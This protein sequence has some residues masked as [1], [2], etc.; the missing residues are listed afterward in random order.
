MPIYFRVKSMSIHSNCFSFDKRRTFNQ[1]V[2]L[3]VFESSQWAGRNGLNGSGFGV[4]TF[5]RV[6]I[7][8]VKTNQVLNRCGNLKRIAR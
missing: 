7:T 8:S 6:Q 4:D 1:M 2:V 3:G 5:R